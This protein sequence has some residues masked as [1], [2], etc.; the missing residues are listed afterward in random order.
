ML[1]E[2]IR[3]TVV[4]RPFRCPARGLFATPI[5]RSAALPTVH[6]TAIFYRGQGWS[7]GNFTVGRV[8][9]AENFIVGRA[10]TAEIPPG[11]GKN[12]GN[13]TL[14]AGQKQRK[15]YPASRAKTAEI[16]VKT[17]EISPWAGG[18]IFSAVFTNF[19]C[20]Y[21]SHGQI[22]AVFTQISAVFTLLAG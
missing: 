5:R 22:S 6:A 11:Q 20:F 17:A 21:P 10:E 8:K 7:S 2:V 13:F 1:E 14:P 4:I 16:W 3:G 15:S 18:I 9:T 12:S 19:R